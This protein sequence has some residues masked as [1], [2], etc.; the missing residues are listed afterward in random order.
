VL[1]G[2]AIIDSVNAFADPT[3]RHHRPRRAWPPSARTAAALVATAGP[4]L[5]TSACGGSATP[6]Q[7]THQ[8]PALAFSRCMRSHGVPNFPDPD[9]QGDFPSF[10][11][12]V[13]KQTSAAADDAC[14]HLLSSGGSPAT[15]QQR[16]QKLAFALKVARCLRTHGFLTFPDPTGSGQVVP[17]GV[18]TDSP[19][20]QAAETNCEKQARQA[21][22][23]P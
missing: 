20:F 23:L 22:G 3:R 21:L 6:A 15:P 11:I 13:S 16:R 14:K 5:L 4:A 18:N 7:S 1:S 8:N 12:T 9:P 10:Q 19:Q 17:P 2:R